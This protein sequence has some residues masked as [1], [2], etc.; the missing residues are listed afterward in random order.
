VTLCFF[1]QH[2]ARA[3][4]GIHLCLSCWRPLHGWICSSIQSAWAAM[5]HLPNTENLQTCQ[6]YSGSNS[7][8]SCISWRQR[9]SL[10]AQVW[11]RLLQKHCAMACKQHLTGEVLMYMLVLCTCNAF[12]CAVHAIGLCMCTGSNCRGSLMH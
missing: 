2:N 10:I 7:N 11:L 8:R 12:P 5:P 3:T 9:R 4:A 1:H 6:G